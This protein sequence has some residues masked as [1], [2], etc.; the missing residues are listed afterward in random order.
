MEDI[1]R[2]AREEVDKI[3]EEKLKDSF[4]Q[5]INKTFIE[6][7]NGLKKELDNFNSSINSQIENLDKQFDKKWNQKIKDEISQLKELTNQNNNNN[8]NIFQENQLGNKYLEDEN[9]IKIINKDFDNKNKN[10]NNTKYNKLE[11]NFDN[12]NNK[13]NNN[14]NNINN[15]E[16]NNNNFD[17]ENEE[18]DE[19]LRKKHI[20]IEAL[21][22]PPL[23]HLT[24]PQDANPLINIILH[25]ISNIH[26]ISE[27]Y[28][29]PIKENKILKKS[30]D[31]PNNNY[32]GPSFI[33]LLDHLWKSNK[34]EYCPNE[35]H[36]DLKKLM[37]N[38]YN[39]KDI[40]KIFNYILTKLHEEINFNP[41]NNNNINDDPYQHHYEDECF[42]AY[43]NNFKQNR[44]VISDYCFSSIE[45]KKKCINCQV[46]SYFFEA[47]PV[48]N[49]F[50]KE[51]E[52]E[53]FNKLNLENHLKTV[54]MAE[55]EENINENCIIC[56]TEQTKLISKDLYSSSTVLIININRDKDPNNTV[57]FEYPEEFD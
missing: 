46:T 47:L 9:D 27:Y 57:S 15:N 10:I 44:T 54:L 43:Q 56:T 2:Q 14:S 21:K 50:L 17:L 5:Q 49:V 18:N 38:N 25:C 37:L 26:Y 12:F 45:I 11:N 3:W 13:I 29:N 30:K 16:N 22:I 24:L 28:L 1:K 6:T 20:N 42:K 51:N 55:E 41:V 19:V 34:K 48:I 31:N 23:I 35:I 32:L 52:N 7:L 8:N 39:S 33:K 4:K 53:D 36:N 40:S